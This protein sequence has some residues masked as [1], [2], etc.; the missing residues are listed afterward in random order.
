MNAVIQLKQY[1]DKAY[2]AADFKFLSKCVLVIRR[3]I[4]LRLMIP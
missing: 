3:K 1:C 4:W 2:Y